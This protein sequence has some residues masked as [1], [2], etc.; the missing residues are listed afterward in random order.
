MR[1]IALI[2]VLAGLAACGTKTESVRNPGTF[3]YAAVGEVTSLDPIFPYDAVSQGM[4]YNVY[5]TLI[6]FEAA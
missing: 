6:A 3:T 4:I 2:A 1:R 5:E